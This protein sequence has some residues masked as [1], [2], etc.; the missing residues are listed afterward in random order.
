MPDWLSE[1]WRVGL[2]LAVALFVW[3]RLR[4]KPIAIDLSERGESLPSRAESPL[5]RELL[6]TLS[7]E[8]WDLLMR[9]GE[10]ELADQVLDLR[11]VDRCRCGDEFCATF[12]VQPKPKDAYGPSHRNITLEPAQGMLVLDLVGDR[13]VAIEVLYRDEIPKSLHTVLP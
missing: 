2:A 4:Q 5:M 13:I 3:W 12:Y 7:Q 11:I 10:P 1:Y 9:E 6:P 8:V